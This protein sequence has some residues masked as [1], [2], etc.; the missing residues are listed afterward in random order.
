MAYY[1]YAEPGPKTPYYNSMRLF[2]Q[3]IYGE[4]NHPFDEIKEL[5]FYKEV[6]PDRKHKPVKTKKVKELE[7][8]VQIK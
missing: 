7:N 8:R 4:W 3:K 2:R 6:Y 1:L 5:N